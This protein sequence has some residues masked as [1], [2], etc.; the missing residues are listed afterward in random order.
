M[1]NLKIRGSWGK[2][3]NHRTDDYQYIAI[4]ALGQ[5]YNFN[6]VVADGAVQTKANNG[7]ITWETTKELDLGFDAGFKNNLINV[8]FDYYDR[9]TDNILAVVPVSLI[10]WTGCS[11]I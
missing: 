11:R 8:S 4:I 6:N 10:F 1:D 9:Y 3:G 7:N 5:N 2:L